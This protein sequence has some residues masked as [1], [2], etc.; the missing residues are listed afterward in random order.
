MV[1]TYI[2]FSCCVF[3]ISSSNCGVVLL[4]VL[5]GVWFRVLSR[6]SFSSYRKIDI[7]QL[8]VKSMIWASTLQI[9][10]HEKFSELD[11][12]ILFVDILPLYAINL[13]VVSL[14]VDSSFTFLAMFVSDVM[15]SINLNE[16]ISFCFGKKKK[17]KFICFY[18]KLCIYACNCR[19]KF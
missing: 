16:W 9:W 19:P 1:F 2:E 18:Y 4:V 12:I 17:S 13:G 7:S 8:Q 15:Y 10:K 5:C 6:C 3:V 11:F 14:F